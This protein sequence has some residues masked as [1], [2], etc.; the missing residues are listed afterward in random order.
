M[1][2]KDGDAEG[3]VWGE[4]SPGTRC[5]DFVEVIVHQAARN[6][7]WLFDDSEIS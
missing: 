2:H 1:E 6:I 5:P 3:W 4:V 7:L